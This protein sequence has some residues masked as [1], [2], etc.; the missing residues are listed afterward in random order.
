MK[1]HI[2]RNHESEKLFECTDC[3][4]QFSTAFDLKRHNK[5]VHDKESSKSNANY[6][7]CSYCKKQFIGTQRL[8]QHISKI[9][10]GAKMSLE[11]TQCDFKCEKGFSL[12]RH[13]LS[14]HERKRS[15]VCSKCNDRFKSGFTLQRH[16][17]I[18]HD[19]SPKCTYCDYKCR[20][21]VNLKKH[22]LKKHG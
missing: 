22:I 2:S 13:I 16:I 14:V 20:T 10:G 5:R 15:Y 11:C 12:K 9:H 6:F 18:V 1:R 4:H 8:R 3:E 7:E 17:L 19:G 21:K